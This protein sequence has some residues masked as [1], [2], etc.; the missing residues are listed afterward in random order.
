MTTCQPNTVPSPVISVAVDPNACASA[1]AC[2]VVFVIGGGNSTGTAFTTNGGSTW[3]VAHLTQTFTTTD[4][5]P[6]PTCPDFSGQD[7]MTYDQ[8]TQWSYRGAVNAG[9]SV[10]LYLDKIAAMGGMQAAIERGFVQQEI[11]NAAYDY[12]R[13]VDEKR[14]IVVGVNDFTRADEPGIPLQRIDEAL[15]RKQIERLKALRLRRNKQAW[16]AA[17]RGVE[18]AARSGANL[19][20][21]IVE[22]VESYATVGEIA[23]RLREVFG[24]YEEA[25]V[26]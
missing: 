4:G 14:S 5:K 24:E 12:Q 10:F 6:I 17:L 2:H 23:T 11:Q 13:A 1:G 26:V 20:P 22:A 18:D 16:A 8:I 7:S 25:V 19:M 3:T 15:E 9:L 21:T